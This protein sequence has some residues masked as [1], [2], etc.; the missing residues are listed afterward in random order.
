MGSIA[1]NTIDPSEKIG[2]R[3]FDSSDVKS[4]T[5]AERPVVKRKLFKPKDGKKVSTDRLDHAPYERMKRI[6]CRTSFGRG[7]RFRGWVYLVVESVNK[8]GRE[9][10]YSPTE[11]NPY[12]A[13][14]EL[15]YPVAD[16]KEDAIDHAQALADIAKWYYPGNN[17][18]TLTLDET[19]DSTPLPE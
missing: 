19:S 9:V 10:I 16:N 1:P 15:P 18:D 6:A 13:D 14:I 11:E 7:P 17:A 4:A 8:D 12:H 5:R 2:R 3:V